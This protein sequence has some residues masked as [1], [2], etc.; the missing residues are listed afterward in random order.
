MSTERSNFLERNA[1][2]SIS[3]LKL[4]I[5]GFRNDNGHVI[6]RGLIYDLKEALK[7]AR[8]KLFPTEIIINAPKYIW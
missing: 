7:L 2:L 6:A 8:Y 5:N 4:E 1:K 3:N